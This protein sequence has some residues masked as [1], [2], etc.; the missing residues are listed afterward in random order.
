[1]ISFVLFG[2][3]S[4]L[5]ALNGINTWCMVYGVWCMEA[6]ECEREDRET[7]I[8]Q[9]RFDSTQASS[10]LPTST[11]QVMRISRKHKV[12]SVHRRGQQKAVF[13]TIVDLAKGFE[14]H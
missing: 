2:D 9:T 5:C 12:G 10:L 1:M 6:R 14:V 3:L 7:Y 4:K 8:I 11:Y 13:A